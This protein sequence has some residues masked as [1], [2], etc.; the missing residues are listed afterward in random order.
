LILDDEDKIDNRYIYFHAHD[1]QGNSWGSDEYSWV[2]KTGES[3]QR[4]F[5]KDMGGTIGKYSQGFTGNK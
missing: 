4:F 2:V 1:E 3:P 5:K